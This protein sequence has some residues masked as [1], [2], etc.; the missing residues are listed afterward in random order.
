MVSWLA[1][2]QERGQQKKFDK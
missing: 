1:R 2:I